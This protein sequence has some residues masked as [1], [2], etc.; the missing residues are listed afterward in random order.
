MSFFMAFVIKLQQL[1]KFLWLFLAL[2][3]NLKYNSMLFSAVLSC[4][5]EPVTPSTAILTPGTDFLP[6]ALE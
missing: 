1:N 6:M 5:T 2:H 4:Q 3:T